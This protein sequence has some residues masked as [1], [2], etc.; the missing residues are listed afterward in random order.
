MIKAI[1]ACDNG[2]GVSK[3]GTIP[4]PKNTKD[5]S[6]FKKNTTNNVVVMGSKTVSYTHLT[7][8]TMLPV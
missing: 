8:P 5:L 7:L 2:G 6:W 1:L 4:W 3:G